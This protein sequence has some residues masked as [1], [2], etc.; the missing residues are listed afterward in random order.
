MIVAPQPTSTSFT[1]PRP[2]PNHISVYRTLYEL[3]A[4]WAQ[5]WLMES[6]NPEPLDALACRGRSRVAARHHLL[7]H[8]LRDPQALLA[9]LQ[10]TIPELLLHAEEAGH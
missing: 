6:A 3:T 8:S 4:L 9:H 7:G 1:R 5:H 10:P 2:T